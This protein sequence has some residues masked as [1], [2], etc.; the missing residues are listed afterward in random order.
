MAKATAGDLARR[1]FYQLGSTACARSPQGC[2]S[3]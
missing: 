1:A 3:W 2:A